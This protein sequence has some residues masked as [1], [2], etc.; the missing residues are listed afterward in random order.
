MHEAK[1]TRCRKTHLILICAIG[2]DV[3]SLREYDESHDTRSVCERREYRTSPQVYQFDTAV[4]DTGRN[5]ST[6]AGLESDVL[7]R[8][9]TQGEFTISATALVTMIK[10]CWIIILVACH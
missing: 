10:A 6:G 3:S 2:T 8:Q 1:A 4:F 9:K 7:A 5:S